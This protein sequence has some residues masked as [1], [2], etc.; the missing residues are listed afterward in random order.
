MSVK[1]FKFVS[2]GIFINEIDNSQLPKQGDDIGP[3]IIGTALRGPSMVPTRIESFSDF[4]ETFGEPL[5][6][7]EGSDVWREGNKLA[8]TYAAYAAQA[9]LRNASPITFVRLL[10]QAHPDGSDH[11]GWEVS[12][13]KEDNQWAKTTGAYGL[14]IA[15]GGA[16][17]VQAKAEIEFNGVI[18][19]DDA[20]FSIDFD[21]DGNGGAVTLT[22]VSGNHPAAKFTVS[23][24]AIGTDTI[25]FAHRDGNTVTV[26][27]LELGGGSTLVN[28]V[29]TGIGDG[30]TTDVASGIAKYVNDAAD[31]LAAVSDA[32]FVVIYEEARQASGSQAT[33]AAGS[34]AAGTG[35]NIDDPAS[36]NDDFGTLEFLEPKTVGGFSQRAL[37]YSFPDETGAL[38][39]SIAAACDS[40]GV[41]GTSL[42]SESVDR[43]LAAQLAAKTVA[44]FELSVDSE[45]L[46]KVVVKSAVAGT[47]GNL[48]TLHINNAQNVVAGN[49]GGG[50]A[51][52]LEDQDAALAAIFYANGQ[53]TISLIGKAVS[54]DTKTYEAI[55]GWVRSDGANNQFKLRVRNSAQNEGDDNNIEDIAFNFNENSRLYARNVLNTNPTLCNQYVAGDGSIK[56][57]FLG[58][59]FDRHLAEIQDGLQTSKGA[60]FAC[61]IPLEGAGDHTSDAA[62][63][64]TPWIISQH[65]GNPENFDTSDGSLL[66]S[67][68]VESYGVEKLMRFHSL[69]TGQWERKNL[70]ISIEDIKAP[71]DKFNPYGSFSVV[72]RKAEDSDAAPVV[73]ERFSSCTLNPASA[74]YVG[75]KVGDMEMRWDDEERRYI[76]YGQYD[77]QSRFIRV[78]VASS[79]EEGLADPR[80]LPF[81]FLGPRQRQDI[82]FAIAGD[83]SAATLKR[84]DAAGTSPDSTGILMESG[85]QKLKRVNGSVQSGALTQIS[86]GPDSGDDTAPELSTSFSATLK[87]PR[88]ALRKTT[89]DS[90]LSSPRDANFGISVAQKGE[91]TA[92]DSSYMDLAGYCGFG[93][94]QL[95]DPT[96]VGSSDKHQF[97]FTL[98]DIRFA[99]TAAEG[100]SGVG[101][102]NVASAKPKNF[103]WEAGCHAG[104]GVADSLSG[105]VDAEGTPGGFEA[106]LKRGIRSFTLPLLG[107]HDGVDVFEV[108]PFAY[109][110][111]SGNE[112]LADA[113]K[114]AL[115]HYAVNTLKKAVDT[116]ADPEVVDM[117]LLAAPGMTHPAITNHMI[118]VCE[119]RGDALAVIDIDNDYMPRGIDVNQSETARLPNVDKAIESLRER[120]LNSSYGCAFFPW[121]QIADTMS[122]RVLWAPPSIAALGTMAS[123]SKKSE[124]WFA[125]A[126]FTRGGLTDGAAGVPVSSVRLRLN[127]KERDKLYEANIN[128]IAQFPAEG[129]VIFGQKTLQVTPSA[130]DRI[131]VRRLMIFLKKQISRMAKTVLFDQNV[132]TT[133]ARFTSKADPFLASVKS[134][135]GLSEYKI[136]LDKTTTTAEL[137]DR[138][139]MYAKILLKPTR[140]IEYIAIDF[141][142]TDSG[143][144]FDD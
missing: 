28:G 5:A 110:N 84:Q 14:F 111:N 19:I 141:V 15:N 96:S 56:S 4:V 132:E 115:E 53:G 98:D 118:S 112:N 99:A 34:V 24:T 67:G 129:I 26:L 80:M 65:N 77:N 11:A 55:N 133:W 71:T 122:G 121:V 6:G 139:I 62:A 134:R 76:S 38:T 51:S 137:V 113:D 1:K 81:G 102:P 54:D 119:K 135:F 18:A 87:F 74:D 47:D 21:K 49:F 7:S 92:F 105:Y 143:A 88:M 123:S 94:Q 126:G 44:D 29:D 45:D 13:P 114:S 40:A 83:E 25:E 12:D 59:T 100:F 130:L 131:N 104:N 142:I 10:G 17:A 107:G 70:K 27:Q 138:N 60:Q 72:V 103:I 127:S 106:V 86:I 89:A 58:E 79:V 144:S 97:I 117:N 32:Q 52:S 91:A 68:A 3:V 35:G 101:D 23:G 22:E 75:K 42:P 61:L 73:V 30:N 93:A 116:V 41:L 124:L 140:A 90:S 82:K 85:E 108:H 136:V 2:P 16:D 46:S 66:E 120:S 109:H 128:P 64:L 37:P 8:P 20:G 95:D 125:P 9:Y 69:Y 57:Y 43:A 33:V 48:D 63:A 39:L 78:E 36:T 50:S 31:G